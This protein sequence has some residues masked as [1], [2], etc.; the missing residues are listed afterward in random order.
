M[1]KKDARRLRVGVLGC[2]P[3][4]QAA[5]F[6]SCTKARNADLFAICDVA[7]DLRERMAWTHA[8]QKS[9]AD[10]DAML[11]DPDLE[12][13]IVAT[14]DAF[15]VPASIRALEAG[16]HVLC[17][18]PIALSI[19][20]AEAL[21]GAVERSGKILQVGHMKRFDA[22]LQAARSFIDTGMG[23]LVALKAWY[24]D[25]THRYAATDAVQPLIVASKSARKPSENPKDDL[26]RYYM[27]AHGS[28]LV[29]TARYFG[30]EIV[31]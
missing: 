8:P 18:K 5:H 27:L 11:A 25:S 12:A 2:G 16:K 9:F 3:I 22:G 19:E 13:V 14:S 4:A 10:Y 24:C 26:E 23:E 21:K 20:E 31:A 7:D 29:D 30:G 15:H 6:E 1:S 17:E 28:H